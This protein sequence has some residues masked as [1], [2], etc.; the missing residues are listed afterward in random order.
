MNLRKPPIRRGFSK[1]SVYTVVVVVLFIC[2]WFMSDN[3]WSIARLL[4][5][6]LPSCKNGKGTCFYV[7]GFQ[8]CGFF[9]TAACLAQKLEEQHQGEV[10]V[11]V[12][13][14]SRESWPQALEET[15]K[16]IPGAE[17]HRT[18]PIVYEGCPSEDRKA[19]T[20]FKFVGGFTEFFQEATKRFGPVDL[21]DCAKFQA[22]R[23]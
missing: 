15:K 16:H 5:F 13:M 2:L 1:A 6:S 17:E 22:Q 19:P 12:T 23:L 4:S 7:E 21:T 11:F 14:R 10:K 8:G 18:S 9:R 20:C 3:K